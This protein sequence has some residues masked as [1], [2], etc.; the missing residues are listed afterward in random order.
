MGVGAD[1]WW[2]SVGVVMEEADHQFHHV[3]K[4][5][6]LLNSIYAHIPPET[7]FAFGTQRKEK[8]DKQHEIDMPNTDPIHWVGEDF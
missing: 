4:W 7:T 8:G 6:F 5:T 2:W 3:T 1:P